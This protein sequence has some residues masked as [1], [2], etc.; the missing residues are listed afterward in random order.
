MAN[1]FGINSQSVSRKDETQSAQRPPDNK[2]PENS[3]DNLDARLY[4]A[5][6]ETFP[7]S[8]PVSVTKAPAPEPPDHATDLSVPDDQP[9]QPEQNSPEII[10]DQ[11][12]GA[13]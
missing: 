12:Q 4:H 13:M 6:E 5:I 9:T 2:L 10:L 8:D 1:T 3:Q 7:T 11:V